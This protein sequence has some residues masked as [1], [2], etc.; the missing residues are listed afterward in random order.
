MEEEKTYRTKTSR[1]S[2]PFSSP[3]FVLTRE[4]SRSKSVTEKDQTDYGKFSPS[5]L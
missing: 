3:S 5:R 2:D 4:R 1:P